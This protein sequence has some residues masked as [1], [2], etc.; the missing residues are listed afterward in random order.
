M[1]GGITYP[2]K[3]KSEV[4]IVRR[5]TKKENDAKSE[6]RESKGQKPLQIRI[7]AWGDIHGQCDVNNSWMKQ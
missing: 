7:W 1:Q 4:R 5:T 2:M 6:A 3:L